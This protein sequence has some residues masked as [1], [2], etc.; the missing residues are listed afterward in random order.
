MNSRYIW[1]IGVGLSVGLIAGCEN[2]KQPPVTMAP[3]GTQAQTTPPPVYQEPPVTPREPA[4]VPG[5]AAGDV[6]NPPPDTT[7]IPPEGRSA[8][9]SGRSS[10][11]TD[12][13]PAPRSHYASSTPK[14]GG[15]YTVKKGDT[16]QKISE[17][18]Y[19]T[20]KKWQKIMQANRKTL[21]DDPKKLRP[22]MKLVIPAK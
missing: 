3:T 8:S 12:H 22:G 16:L 4:P 2:Q 21:K 19:G 14:S 15:S 7:P 17:K 1:A 18:Y 13:K 9:R 5:Q 10:K 20:T 11:A 6:Y